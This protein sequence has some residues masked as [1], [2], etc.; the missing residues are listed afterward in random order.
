MLL[1]NLKKVF[2]C[3]CCCG[4]TSTNKKIANIAVHNFILYTTDIFSNILS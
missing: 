4:S 1:Q 2:K 3:L